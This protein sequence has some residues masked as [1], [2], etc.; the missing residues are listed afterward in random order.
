MANRN[1][2]VIYPGRFQPFHKGHKEVYNYLV[3]K[4]NGDVYITTTDVIDP[5][6]SPFSFDDKKSIMELCGIPVN[7]ILQVKSNYNVKDIID[8]IPIILS[9]DILIF[10]VSD[11]DMAEDPRF[12]TFVKRDGNPTYL[13]PYPKNESKALLPAKDHGY[14]LTVPTHTFTVLNR[15]IKSATEL[16][17]LYKSLDVNKKKEFI[18]DLFGKY[19]DNIFNI[20]NNKLGGLTDKQYTGLK[21]MIS[22]IIREEGFLDALVG[23]ESEYNK[24]LDSIDDRAAEIQRTAD[25]A[26]DRVKKDDGN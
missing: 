20:M 16:R 11:K 25:D 19:S 6:K 8:K 22:G 15:S 17:S 3:T 23:D 1:T 26:I 7:K 9:R 24:A 18:K 12:K 13:Q 4:F 5:S 10:V 2:F 21:E 14:L